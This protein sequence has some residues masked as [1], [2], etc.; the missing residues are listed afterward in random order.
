M[1][2]PEWGTPVCSVRHGVPKPFAAP[3]I[4]PS[5]R[6]QRWRRSGTRPARPRVEVGDGERRRFGVRVQLRHLGVDHVLEVV[7]QGTEV[8][9]ALHQV[10]LTSDQMAV[11]VD[12]DVVQ[13]LLG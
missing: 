6:W 11:A 9:D 2:G 10:G 12:P 8:G 3:T 13:H 5:A 7:Q 1:V 4:R